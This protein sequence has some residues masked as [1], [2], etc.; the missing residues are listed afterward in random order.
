MSKIANWLLSLA[1]SVS[2]RS[3]KWAN[4]FLN[5]AQNA[6]EKDNAK[7]KI[8]L[9]DG[10]GPISYKFEKTTSDTN[11]AWDNYYPGAGLFIRGYA[12]EI[13]IDA[14]SIRESKLELTEKAKLEPV[15]NANL[16]KSLWGF[17]QGGDKQ[18]QLSYI[19][20]GG[21]AILI[22]MMMM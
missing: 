11:T 6:A 2:G 10:D 20:I 16:A 17:A 14:D 3:S 8:E 15:F 9:P 5:M 13:N 18:E 7:L 4:K 12:Q 21:L 1:N 22:V 19:I